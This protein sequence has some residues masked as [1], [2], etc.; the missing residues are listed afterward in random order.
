MNKKIFQL[1]CYWRLIEGVRPEMEAVRRGFQTVI[2]SNSMKI[3]FPSEIELLF[4]GCPESGHS[5]D[6]IWSKSALQQ[7]IRPDHGFTHDSMQITWL[8]EMLNSFNNEKV[9]FA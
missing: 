4:C 8:V 1:V 9:I 5:T 6:K 2:N 3:F 7:A